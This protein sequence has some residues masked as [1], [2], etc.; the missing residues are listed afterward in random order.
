MVKVFDIYEK[1]RSFRK[2]HACVRSI[3][4]SASNA[5]C[6]LEIGLRLQTW[7][8]FM[9]SIWYIKWVFHLI[10]QYLDQEIAKVIEQ[11]GLH[12]AIIAHLH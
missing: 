2:I 3:I 8:Y 4:I 1:S 9:K 11:K 7:I 6:S 12:L 5:P 10:L